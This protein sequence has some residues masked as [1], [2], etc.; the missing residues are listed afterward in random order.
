MRSGKEGA[1]K[2]IK[3]CIRPS[4]LEST[5]ASLAGSRRVAVRLVVSD[6]SEH[7]DTDFPYT[8]AESPGR[9]GGQVIRIEAVC[10]EGEADEVF[11]VLSRAARDTEKKGPLVIVTSL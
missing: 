2:L 1:L 7:Q 6:A 5:V 9:D 10:S 4:L 3:T 11:D 8:L